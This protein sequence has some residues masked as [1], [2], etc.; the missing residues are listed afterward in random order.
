MPLWK[1]QEDHRIRRYA[2]CGSVVS[3]IVSPPLPPV[4]MPVL[5]SR[6]L[7]A[8]VLL[9]MSCWSAIPDYQRVLFFALLLRFVWCFWEGQC[10]NGA[11]DL[12]RSWDQRESS[13]ICWNLCLISFLA[14]FYIIQGLNLCVH[15]RWIA[16]SWWMRLQPL[17][18]LW[19]ESTLLARDCT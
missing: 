18:L 14:I 9:V 8:M 11:T 5:P 12:F 3:S 16:L 4:L 17:C 7:E 10:R 2:S 1:F 15:L 19:A 6:F 13:L